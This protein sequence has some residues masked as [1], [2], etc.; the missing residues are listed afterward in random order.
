MARETNSGK[1][2]CTFTI[3]KVIKQKFSI[4]TKILDLNLSEVVEAMMENFVDISKDRVK[5]ANSKIYGSDAEVEIKDERL[6]LL[7]DE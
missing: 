5:E 3:D 1:I 6:T 4:A 2:Y 7:Q